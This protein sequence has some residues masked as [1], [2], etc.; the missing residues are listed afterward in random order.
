[1]L[2]PQLS[3]TSILLLSPDHTGTA[4]PLL[5]TWLL[6]DRC[7]PRWYVPVLVCLLFT[8]TMVADSIVL[9]TGIV[10]LMLVGVG[11]ACRRADQARD[12]ARARVV[13]AEPGRRGRGGRRWPGRS[14]RG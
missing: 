14:G 12:T 11:R 5:V 4:V 8:L 9:L 10:P 6:I 1:M 3:A 13:R 7:R 2:S